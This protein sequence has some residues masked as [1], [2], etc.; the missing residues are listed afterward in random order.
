MTDRSYV[1][2]W[3]LSAVSGN[4][5]ICD[6]VIISLFMLFLVTKRVLLDTL[7]FRINLNYWTWRL[8]SY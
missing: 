8:E 3:S 6:T 2:F 7:R 1:D 5:Y 4:G